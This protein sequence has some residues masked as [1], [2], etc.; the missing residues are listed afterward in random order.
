[1]VVTVIRTGRHV[2]DL[3]PSRRLSLT[4]YETYTHYKDL[5]ATANTLLLVCA[6]NALR[7]RSSV[8]SVSMLPGGITPSKFNGVRSLF[9]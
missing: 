9:F 7:C 6:T 2:V 8:C 3:K 5:R 1:V 4:R